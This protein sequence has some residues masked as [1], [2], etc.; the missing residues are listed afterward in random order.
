MIMSCYEIDYQKQVLTNIFINLWINY[1]MKILFDF[2]SKV[3]STLYH[4][5]NSVVLVLGFL[6]GSWSH[7]FQRTKP[8][9]VQTQN[10]CW[11]V[12]GSSMYLLGQQV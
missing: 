7:S 8:P 1:G 2:M 10:Q 6:L 4:N 5:N 3:G 11:Q 12:Q 9:Q